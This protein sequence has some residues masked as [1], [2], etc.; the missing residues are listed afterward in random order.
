MKNYAR[1]AAVS[2]F[3]G[4][5]LAG[6]ALA[7]AHAQPVV[8]GGVVN[9]TIVDAADVVIKDVNVAVGAALA[10]AANVCDVNVL[11]VDLG[12]EAVTCT[13][14]VTGQEVTISQV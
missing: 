9:V 4:A 2:L 3:A 14:E 13:N 8:T 11:A 12:N 5:A 7:P 1:N 10:I 6:A